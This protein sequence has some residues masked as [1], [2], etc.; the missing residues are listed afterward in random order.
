MLVFSQ[1]SPFSSLRVLL[2]INF[3]RS[4]LH[5]FSVP[6]FATF[7]ECLSRVRVAKRR[8]T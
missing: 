2:V 1:A 5:L 6:Q 4:M 8:W 3:S 7:T